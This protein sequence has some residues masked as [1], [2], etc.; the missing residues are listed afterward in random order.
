[1]EKTFLS[2]FIVTCYVIEG[3]SHV[4]HVYSFVSFSSLYTTS[5]PPDFLYGLFPKEISLIL[6]EDKTLLIYFHLLQVI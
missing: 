2:V 6:V 5:V 4:C 1:M 3:C